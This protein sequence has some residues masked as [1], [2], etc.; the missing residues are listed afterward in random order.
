MKRT[1]YAQEEV[2]ESTSSS[3][4]TNHT[5]STTSSSESNSTL[6]KVYIYSSPFC[7]YCQQLK[8]KLEMENILHKVIIIEDTSWFP[9]YVNSIP[10]TYSE[11]TNETIIGLPSDMTE[12]QDKI[13]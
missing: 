5:T 10:H 6:G 4:E 13:F 1:R 11:I 12:Y 2:E 3:S 9:S 8:K 7:S